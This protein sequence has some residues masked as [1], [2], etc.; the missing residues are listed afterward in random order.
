MKLT[1]DLLNIEGW[2]AHRSQQCHE[3]AVN[4]GW[5]TDLK[6]GLKKER[7]IGEILALIHSEISEA[8]LGQGQ[9][10]DKLPEFQGQSVEIVDAL[11]R[12]FDFLGSA[13]I[14][15]EKIAAYALPTLTGDNVPY[16]ANNAH[17]LTSAL[18]EAYRRN[19]V[20]EIPTCWSNLI[21]WLV[22]Y[23]RKTGYIGQ[24]D[25]IIDAKLEFNQQRADH[26]IENRK[27]DDGKKF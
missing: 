11:I 19:R 4:A 3:I 25:T 7:N 21:G 22:V 13:E 23:F 26:K 27:L 10:D 17:T 18:M 8:Y 12:I 20:A 24:L 16:L 6:T 2:V 5:W 9:P 14:K 15:L 1:L